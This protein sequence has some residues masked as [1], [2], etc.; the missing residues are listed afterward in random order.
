MILPYI[1]QNIPNITTQHGFKT[2]HSTNTALHNI[3]NTVATGFNPPIP[4]TRTIAV[5]LDMSKAFDTVNIHTLIDKL[6]QTNIPHTILRYIANYIK[7]RMAYTTFRNHTST[8]RQFKSGVPQGGVLSPI[9]FNIY[10]SDIP[11]P[12]DSVQLT[13]YADDITITA[14]HTDI[15]IA[16]A[17]IQPYLQDVLKWTK[18]N[19]LLLNTDKTTCTLLTPD[20]AEYNKQL[21]LQI[22]NTTL[23]MTTHPKILGLTLDPKLTYNRHID[24]AATKARKT[25]NI[26]K[27]LTSTKWGKHTETILAT[28]KAITRPVL[29]HASTIWSPNASETNIDKLQIV[30]NTALR[31][32][33]G[34]T[35]DTNTQ[36]LH[37]ETNVLPIHQHLQLHAS[38]IRQ[39]A[40][41][42]T[43]NTKAR[44]TI[45]ILKVLTS[46]KWGKH[47]ETILATYKA[48]TRPVLE[49]ASTIWS[50]NASETNI[51]KLQIVQN[52]ALRIATGCTHDT[53]TQHL[54]DETN[55]L[56][57]HQHLQL[58]ASQIRQKAQHPTHPL[59]KLT[60][61][62]H[63]PRLKKQTTFNNINYTT[64]IDT[65]P[66]TVTQQISANSTQ[67]HTSIVQT[68]LMQRNHNKLIHQHAPKISP[69]EL[70]LPRET[71][72]TLAQLRTNKSPILISYLHKV[73]ETHHPSPLC[74]LCKTH[75]HTTDHLFNCTHLYTSS[76][77]LD[78][79]LSPEIVAPLLIRWKRRLA[80]LL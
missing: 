39:K 10:T 60:I 30:Q 14:P 2:K 27:V 73:D 68:H 62:P 74:P 29:E 71:R 48:I 79:W 58:H 4:P 51:D 52:T 61:D 56:P 63:T 46:T 57:I 76:N 13:P 1:T 34:C 22:D 45:N 72:R 59:H 7:G 36:H 50:P 70:S 5:A 43:H 11:L 28:Y 3:N 75:P 53:N 9:L 21:G 33:T 31:I 80:G 19:D 41:H 49:Y 12:P 24:L 8:K 26:L 54:H 44:K 6:T 77:I 65:H 15:N 35:H 32:A 37:D 69:S 78:L 20:P 47:T 67:I 16:K 18:D 64:N 23:P 25:I 66:D 42:P 55:V 38:Q 40:Q 17:N